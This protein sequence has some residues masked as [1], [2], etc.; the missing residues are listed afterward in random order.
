MSQSEF[1]IQLSSVCGIFKPYSA[2]PNGGDFFGPNIDSV[3]SPSSQLFLFS[4]VG[5]ISFLLRQFSLLNQ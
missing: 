1:T 3:L 4:E 5:N 2:C